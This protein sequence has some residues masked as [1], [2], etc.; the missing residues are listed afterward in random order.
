MALRRIIILQ[1]Y[2]SSIILQLYSLPALDQLMQLSPLPLSSPP[3]FHLHYEEGRSVGCEFSIVNDLLIQ[4]VNLVD[5]RTMC[6]YVIMCLDRD[7]STGGHGRLNKL[8][9]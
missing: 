8:I 7:Q 9:I 2:Y 1:L 6:G 4:A 3:M 5:V